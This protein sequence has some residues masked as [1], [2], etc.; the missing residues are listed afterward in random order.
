MSL[1]EEKAELIAPVGHQPVRQRVKLFNRSTLLYV[2]LAAVGYGSW[3]YAHQ[4]DGMESTSAKD[5][6]F[7]KFDW[8]KVSFVYRLLSRR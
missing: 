5:L 2:V 7:A 8:A 1:Q 3:M 4:C 6:S